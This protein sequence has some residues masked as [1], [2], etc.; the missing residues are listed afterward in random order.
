MTAP[1]PDGASKPVVK[2]IMSERV[3]LWE[4]ADIASLRHK[5]EAPAREIRLGT[6]LRTAQRAT[7]ELAAVLISDGEISKA[8]RLSESNGLLQDIA[9]AH[10]ALLPMHP[11]RKRMD[12]VTIPTDP[13]VA[14]RRDGSALIS[15]DALLKAVAKAPAHSAP[16]IDGMRHEHLKVLVQTQHGLESV[17]AIARQIARGDVPAAV[18]DLLATSRLVAFSKDTLA[19][20]NAARDSAHARNIPFVPAVRPIGIGLV[21]TRIT[22][23]ALIETHL[24]AITAAILPDLQHGFRNR[25]GAELIQHA[26]RIGMQAAPAAGCL[27]LDLRNAFNTVSRERIF[28]I[29]SDTP[30]LAYL[31]PIYRLLYLDRHAPLLLY[32]GDHLHA[33]L[34]SAEGVRQGCVLGMAIFCL[35]I[36]PHLQ[37][38]TQLGGLPFGYADDCNIM[39]T[40]TQ[41]KRIMH[42]LPLDLARSGLFLN[43]SKVK[44]LP[45]TGAPVAPDFFEGPHDIQEEDGVSEATHLAQVVDGL[46]ILGGPY[47]TPA[48]ETSTLSN[49]V[50]AHERLTVL[51]AEIADTG[52]RHAAIRL[53][54]TAACRRHQHLARALDPEVSLPL[55]HQADALNEAA[56]LFTLDVQTRVADDTEAENLEILRQRLHHS[57]DYGGYNLI[58]QAE[59][60]HVAHYASLAATLH[61]L[62][63]LMLRHAP[64]QF[65]D[66]IRI[67]VAQPDPAQPWAATAFTAYHAVRSAADVPQDIIDRAH[68][69][70][71]HPRP[72]VKAGRQHT[73][74]DS[75]SG[76]KQPRIPLPGELHLRTIR[77]LQSALGP[78]LRMRQFAA[79]ESRLQD[80]NNETALIRMYGAAAGGATH[81]VS[82]DP[83]LF[84]APP[85]LQLTLHRQALGLITLPSGATDFPDGPTCPNCKIPA[86]RASGRPPFYTPCHALTDHIPR[87]RPADVTEMHNAVVSTLRDIA[88]A[89]LGHPK[90]K[91]AAEE[92]GLRADQTRPADLSLKDYDGPG[93][94]LYI[95]V[96]ITSAYTKTNFP[97]AST[98]G[99]LSAIAENRKFTADRRSG[100]PLQHSHRLVPFAIE[101]NGRLGDHAKSLL[102]EWHS[103]LSRAKRSKT[104]TRRVNLYQTWSQRIV[105]TLRLSLARALLHA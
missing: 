45:P 65:A 36:A 23:S 49:R 81:A 9:E 8:A 67:S 73:R 15:Q 63:E 21:L 57:T 74:V 90:H 24:D 44:F 17:L 96:T 99:N 40:P 82:D 56:M 25:S 29:I 68:R 69:V 84:Q 20:T 76:Y 83:R 98:P 88:L 91:L 31:L 94:H 3:R 101:T 93:R 16:G 102:R 1:F 100:Q 43:T 6:G 97:H 13:L 86:S 18:A 72:S 66:S 11:P 2:A 95:D 60:R 7:A 27:Q 47:G 5:A 19:N 71:P 42:S 78:A 80:T 54:Q 70:T 64:N 48:F 53:I 46:N 28:Q 92:P 39:C 77:H 38:I 33:T 30:A 105:V 59:E 87:C 79:T 26:V 10:A 35:A 51:A 34:A 61:N 104:P 32:D 62:H 52:Q 103:R 85:A 14:P 55:L 37:R 89:D 75:V 58:R 50:V 12:D 41:A 4:L 22:T